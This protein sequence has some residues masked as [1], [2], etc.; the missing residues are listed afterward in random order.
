[1]VV[2]LLV[3]FVVYVRSREK[4]GKPIWTE[5]SSPTSVAVSVAKR[6]PSSATD[7]RG[8]SSGAELQ[9]PEAQ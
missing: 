1:M 3:F 4:G 7:G 8:Q 6:D 9:E 2:G 5:L